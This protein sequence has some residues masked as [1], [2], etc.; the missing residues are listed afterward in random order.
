MFNP[1][2]VAMEEIK[3]VSGKIAVTVEQR[4]DATLEEI[5]AVPDR[6]AEDVKDA[7]IEVVMAIEEGAGVAWK[8]L[9]ETMLLPEA[10]AVAATAPAAKARAG[11]DI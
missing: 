2:D 5:W 6:M 11:V 3:A 9:E 8:R 10:P 7:L 1:G 4:V